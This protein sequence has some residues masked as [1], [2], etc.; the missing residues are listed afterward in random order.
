MTELGADRSLERLDPAAL[1]VDS[2]ERGPND[3]VLA[4]CIESL[5][6]EQ[7]AVLAFCEETLLEPLDPR[8]QVR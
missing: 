1:R 5:E 2:L 7:H 8:F 3:A 6:H 4:G